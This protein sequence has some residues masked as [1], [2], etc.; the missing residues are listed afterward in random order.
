MRIVLNLII[1]LLAFSATLSAQNDFASFDRQAYDYYIKGD[2]KNL[3]TITSNILKQGI[4][5]YYLRMRIGLLSYNKQRY[6]VAVKHL[7]KALEFNS[8]D[9]ISREY[10]YC[11][12][13]YS[14]RKADAGLFLESIPPDNRNL[15]LRSVHKP[16]LSEIY[17]GTSAA[18]YDVILYTFNK[19]NYE[20]IKYSYGIQAGFESYLS[21]RFK[22][23]VAFTNYNK[24]G[25][26]YS[27]ANP[28][29]GD[30]NFTQNQIYARLTGYVFTGWEILAFG[31]IV[32]YKDDLTSGQMGNSTTLRVTEY[33]GG[34]GITKIGWKI[35]TGVN[36]SFSNFSNSSQ[37]RG[38]GYLTWLPAGNLNFY[39]TSGGMYQ[40]DRVWGS[41][42]QINQEIGLKVI[43]TLWVEAGIVQGNS[44]LYSRNQG[45]TINNSFQVP[46]TTIYSNLIILPWKHLSLT[47]SPYFTENNTYSWDLNASVRTAK[48]N[49]SSFGS[50]VRLTYKFR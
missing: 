17:F 7:G 36:M 46:A 34:A 22:G 11:S 5:Y 12:Y 42:Y 6:P 39:L 4:D 25:T 38:E 1:L 16:G 44:F 30:L 50:A 40:N 21:S 23:T 18:G 14:G 43:K 28:A 32:F 47:L 20:A 37:I 19:L 2:Y 3:K 45:Y 33:L 29:G 27:P 15:T 10:I 41:T 49:L 24:S 31:N 26:L 13:L 35:R 9:T 8:L 48:L